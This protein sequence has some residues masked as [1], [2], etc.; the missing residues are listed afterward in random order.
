LGQLQC[1]PKAD[2]IRAG[3]RTHDAAFFLNVLCLDGFIPAGKPIIGTRPETPPID[4]HK[5][6]LLVTGNPLSA[7][8]VAFAMR[9]DASVYT[10]SPLDERK[11]GRPAGLPQAG[12]RDFSRRRTARRTCAGSIRP[13]RR[14]MCWTSGQPRIKIEYG[15][16][17]CAERQP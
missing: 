14:G 10:R 2:A 5:A 8:C 16:Q 11:Y 15:S 6:L 3:R 17:T 9:T 13:S 1:R 7:Q 4:H 12:R